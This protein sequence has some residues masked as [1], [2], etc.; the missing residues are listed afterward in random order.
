MRKPYL[1][2]ALLSLLLLVPTITYS[3]GVQIGYTEKPVLNYGF[4]NV[5]TYTYKY[6][7]GDLYGNMYVKEKTIKV[8][9]GWEGINNE[10]NIFGVND[11]FIS[12]I[13]NVDSIEV[14]DDALMVSLRPKSMVLL[15]S[16]LSE[17]LQLS[18][19]YLYA[20][21]K[22]EI[23]TEVKMI[24]DSVEYTQIGIGFLVKYRD[25]Y[26]IV[27]KTNVN[28]VG[29]GINNAFLLKK[30]VEI[31]GN[32]YRGINKQVPIIPIISPGTHIYINTVPIFN[33]E[34]GKWNKIAITP[35]DVIYTLKWF[36]DLTFVKG[37][38]EY[39][40]EFNDK[41]LKESKVIGAVIVL[42]STYQGKILIKEIKV[43]NVQNTML[44]STIA[45]H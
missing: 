4:D 40:L 45:P 6:V 26:Y 27:L 13:S 42:S 19:A 20:L 31:D 25:N 23:N 1:I 30:E 17:E 38:E 41:V 3:L 16:P 12:L 29:Y 10:D 5:C 35:K 36:K 9:C 7:Y 15:F 11:A 39:V 37:E 32:T 22:P 34:Q 28:I 44:A 18:E 43:L 2:I 24:N 33:Y 8:P 14:I 21:V